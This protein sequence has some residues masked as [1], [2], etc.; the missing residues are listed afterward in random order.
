MEIGR[1]RKSNPKAN[2]NQQG[3]G[4]QKQGNGN[5]PQAHS[6][7]QGNKF[8]PLSSKQVEA[9]EV[10]SR[11]EDLP[12]KITPKAPILI[13][14][15]KMSQKIKSLHQRRMIKALKAQRRKRKYMD[16][17]IQS[18]GQQGD[19]RPPVRNENMKHIRTSYKAAS[20]CWK[21][22]WEKTPK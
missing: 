12:G 1:K 16:H 5:Q 20:R 21:K 9:Q 10:E 7:E 17:K 22:L 6:K 11:Q 4:K 8:D 14:P 2:T 3:A 15:P 13:T 18:E 19:E